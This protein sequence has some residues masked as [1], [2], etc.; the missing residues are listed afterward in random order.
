MTI[1][2]WHFWGPTENLQRLHFICGLFMTWRVHSVQCKLKPEH[3]LL[4]GLTYSFCI[5]SIT[6]IVVWPA[7]TSSL[8]P[9][10]PLLP[11]LPSPSLPP[12]SLPSPSLPPPFPSLPPPPHSQLS[13][14]KQWKLDVQEA[15]KEATVHVGGIHKI[16]HP[17][18]YV[19]KLLASI[20]SHCWQD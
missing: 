7:S 6:K 14:C 3:C 11:S 8:P 18:N 16:V 15:G 20:Y 9:S 13:Y 1:H 2:S 10:L 17:A 4:N 19:S 12:F 5:S